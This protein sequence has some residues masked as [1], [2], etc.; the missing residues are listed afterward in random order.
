MLWLGLALAMVVGASLGML[1]GGGSV[2]AVPIFVYVLGYGTKEAVAMSLAVVGATSL[3][4]ALGHWRAGRVEWRVAGI[5]GSVA[6]GGTYLGARLAVFFSGTA[7]LLLFATI[8]IVAA[9]FMYRGRNPLL[10]REGRGGRMP[11]M[12]V[13][14]E[15][16]A[17]GMLTGLVGVGGG[18]L[19]VPAL[20][21]LGGVGMKEAVGTSLVVISMNSAAGLAGYLG[22]V[23]IPWGFA[24]AFIAV[25]IVGSLAGTRAVRHVPQRTL[26]KSFAIFLVAMGLLILFQN[27]GAI[28]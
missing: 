3:F 5:F 14:V 7:Q 9:Y 11:L 18:F 20:V 26:E 1:G 8:M 19:I 16:L 25:A 12:L 4:A 27:H 6:M 10:E 21:L 22:Q 28:F 13:A 24:A 15:G 23:D 2:L 17:V